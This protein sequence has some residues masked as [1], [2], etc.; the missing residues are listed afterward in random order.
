MNPLKFH[1]NYL[2]HTLKETIFI[3]CWIFKSSQIY[4]LVCI[5][6]R[7]PR[8][9]KIDSNPNEQHIFSNKII[10]LL[11]FMDKLWSAYCEIFFFF[12]K[13]DCVITRLDCI[14]KTIIPTISPSRSCGKD[15]YIGWRW[16]IRWT[17]TLATP[18]GK[19]RNPR[20]F[21]SKCWSRSSC[22][23][24]TERSAKVS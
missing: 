16:C 17:K 13:I 21:A 22:V 9:P 19:A 7:L 1:T 15:Q 8:P 20:L 6:E 11:K 2:T 12:N 14:P 4:E 24:S 18:S 5:F 3:Q 23:N 10:P